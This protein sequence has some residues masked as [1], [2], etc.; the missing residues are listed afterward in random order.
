VGTEKEGARE[1]ERGCRWREMRN[2]VECT[3]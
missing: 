3:T 2:D 1:E